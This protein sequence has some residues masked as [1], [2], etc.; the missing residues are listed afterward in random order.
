MKKT[1][2]SS[3]HLAI[4]KASAQMVTTVA[5]AA[6]ITVFSLIAASSLWSERGYLS[7]VTSA[8]EK[9]RNQLQANITAVNSLTSHY[10]AFISTPTNVIGG[11]PNGTG[12]NDGDNAKIVLDAL[13]PQY[14]FPALAS[15]LEKI[16]TD[17]NL[18]ISNITGTDD[19]LS[20]QNNTSSPNPQPVSM[21]FTFGI[22]NASYSSIQNLIGVLQSS[23]RPI[24]IDTMTLSG[25]VNN[26]QLTVSA[27]TYY[28]PGKS[29]QIG[30]E[31]I[32]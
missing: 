21:P 9:A 8:K 17:R 25:G 3:K 11:N 31:V 18:S 1:A 10:Q 13:P 12:D 23:I 5:I 7:R 26:M 6:F 27:H 19:E 28:Q 32:K 4:D 15:S 20:Q 14:D 30:S 2:I 24:Q 16:L 22:G 29:L